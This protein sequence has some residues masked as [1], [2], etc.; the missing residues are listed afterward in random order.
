MAVT[1]LKGEWKS[2]IITHLEQSVMMIGDHWMLKWHVNNLDSHLWVRKIL[3]SLQ[4]L[5][6]YLG[7]IC[8]SLLVNP[9]KAY[10]YR[11]HTYYE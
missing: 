7:I 9:R 6:H 8:H 10:L 11:L 5:L 2:V 1:A 4:L 3:I